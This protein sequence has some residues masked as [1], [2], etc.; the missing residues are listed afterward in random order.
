MSIELITPFRAEHAAVDTAV[1]HHAPLQHD[2]TLQQAHAQFRIDTSH[3]VPALTSEGS[4]L[5]GQITVVFI[6]EEQAK[7]L[8]IN[9]VNMILVPR[10]LDVAHRVMCAPEDHH[11]V[12]VYDVICNLL[13]HALSSP[14]LFC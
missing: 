8:F 2:L 5:I 12:M 14:F 9:G 10:P 11:R 4:L 3:L 13:H 6:A 7:L 1:R